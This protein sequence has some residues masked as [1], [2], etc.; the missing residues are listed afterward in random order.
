MAEGHHRLRL[1]PIPEAPAGADTHSAGKPPYSVI[2]GLR[3]PGSAQQCNAGE[4]LL[5]RNQK[6]LIESDRGPQ[7]ATVLLGSD[8]NPN[9][10]RLPKVLRPLD[11]NDEKKSDALR[12]DEA[13]YLAFA[14][15]RA[16]ELSLKM[17]L[18]SAEISFNRTR[19]V[20]HFT[21]QGRIDFRELVKD[22]AKQ[23]HMRIELRQ[24]GVRDAAAHIGGIGSCGKEL[25]CSSWLPEFQP[26]SI[27]MA[28]DQ[29]LAVNHDKLSGA[30]GRLKCCLR[31][32][33]DGYAEARKHLPK[34]GQKVDTPQGPG[35]VMDL[36][37]L[38]LKVKVVL[39]GGTV[40]T[41]GHREVVRG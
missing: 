7:L 25:C 34:V 13:K 11:E 26:V 23:L 40:K 10:H 16:A 24:I 39:E 15:T 31:Y 38:D 8:P 19:A 12:R 4:L 20:F 37:V 30:C 29:G 22:L 41:F 32:E 1:M 33:Q 5:E 6:V 3:T 36:M 28:K 21:S 2:V 9:A 14:K 27:R 18:A 35:K 17:K